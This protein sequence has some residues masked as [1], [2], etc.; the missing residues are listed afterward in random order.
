MC[1]DTCTISVEATTSLQARSLA[2]EA[3]KI[4][5]EPVPDTKVKHILVENRDFTEAKVAKLERRIPLREDVTD[6]T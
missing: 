2:A 6:S 1:R 4:Y 3:L 5:P